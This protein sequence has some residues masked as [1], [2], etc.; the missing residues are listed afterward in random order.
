MPQKSSETSSN[1]FSNIRPW[2]E[3]DEKASD[4]NGRLKKIPPKTEVY[5]INGPM[6]FATSDMV[7]SIPIKAGVKVIII[8]MR[9][10]PALD[11]SALKELTTV[12]EN[13]RKQEITVL[14]SHVN[15][16]PLSVMKKA[17]FYDMV[18]EECFPENID[19]ALRLAKKLSK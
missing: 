13:L 2:T 19:E 18:G 17:G 7:S 16:Q 15:E 1:G 8:R 3:A 10:I 4:D 6:F 5:E 14:F 9:N 12:Y 11:V